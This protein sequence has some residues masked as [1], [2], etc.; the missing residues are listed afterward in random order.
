MLCE[1]NSFTSTKVNIIHLVGNLHFEV[2]CHV[3]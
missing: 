3:I 2:L 1:D